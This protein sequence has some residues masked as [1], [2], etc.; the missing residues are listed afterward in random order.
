MKRLSGLR[1][2]YQ[3]VLGPDGEDDLVRWAQTQFH[4]LQTVAA[5]RG[6]SPVAAI[7]SQYEFKWSRLIGQSDPTTS[8]SVGGTRLY[9]FPWPSLMFVTTVDDITEFRV[10]E[11]FLN[12]EGH[13]ANRID[14]LNEELVK[15]H[16]GTL[17]KVLHLV[18][19]KDRESIRKGAEIVVESI[20]GLLQ[21]YA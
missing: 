14:V 19:D 15:W 3:A 9:T 12:P 16:P 7:Q 21:E 13:L 11:F 17:A 1:H 6:G 5:N 8:E 2:E 4:I 18:I 10:R 20:V